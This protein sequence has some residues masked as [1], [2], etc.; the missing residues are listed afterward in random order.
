[1]TKPLPEPAT[2]ELCF[3]DDNT[4]EFASD[5]R[6]FLSLDRIGHTI[7]ARLGGKPG[8]D[9]ARRGQHYHDG[10]SAGHCRRLRR[11]GLCRSERL[12]TGLMMAEVA[13]SR[14]PAPA[15]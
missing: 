13:P 3:R 11:G 10:D 8:L 1:M 15:G 12:R 4:G 14:N 9:R 7:T 6:R 2:R 5:G